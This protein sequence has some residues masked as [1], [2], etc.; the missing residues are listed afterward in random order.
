ME[1]F[2]KISYEE[3]KKA[4]SDKLKALAGRNLLAGIAVLLGG[5]ATATFAGLHGIDATMPIII[6]SGLGGPLIGSFFARK[7]VEKKLEKMDDMLGYNKK[8]IGV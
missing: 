8:Q 6:S 1:E 4:R 5:L 2:N 3:M 7:R